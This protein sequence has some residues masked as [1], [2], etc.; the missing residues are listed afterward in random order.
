MKAIAFWDLW[1]YIR[2]P[3]RCSRPWLLVQII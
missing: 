3:V 1:W 2:F